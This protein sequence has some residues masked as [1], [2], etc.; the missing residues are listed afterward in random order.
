[1]ASG[2]DHKIP[3]AV[4]DGRHHEVSFPAASHPDV[5]QSLPDYTRTINPERG[6]PAADQRAT[7]HLP[8]KK[9]DERWP[10]IFTSVT[11]LGVPKRLCSRG[12]YSRSYSNITD[13]HVTWNSEVQKPQWK[14]PTADRPRYW[15]IAIRQ[16]HCCDGIL[17]FRVGRQVVPWLHHHASSATV[18][19]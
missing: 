7:F 18:P 11:L 4:T 17:Y 3:E 1:M 6:V 2:T 15:T 19:R 9:T 12:R 13:S 16:R 14:Q 8:A 10:I 5:F